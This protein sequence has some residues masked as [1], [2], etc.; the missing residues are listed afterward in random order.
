MAAAFTT[1]LRM[2]QPGIPWR[3]DLRLQRQ[4]RSGFAYDASTALGRR[5][6]DSCLCDRQSEVRPAYT[7]GARRDIEAVPCSRPEEAP[8]FGRGG[9]RRRVASRPTV[10]VFGNQRGRAEISRRSANITMVA[11][12]GQRRAPGVARLRQVALSKCSAHVVDESWAVNFEIGSAPTLFMGHATIMIV[13]TRHG[14]VAYTY[15]F[16]M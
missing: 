7:A 14:W 1:S 5:C 8:C 12:L 16:G 15:R 2:G 10:F 11:W 3:R 6:G 13:R 4:E 9:G